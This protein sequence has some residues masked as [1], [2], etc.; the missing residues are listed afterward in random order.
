[1]ASV[2]SKH[3][4]LQNDMLQTVKGLTVYPSEYFNPKDWRTGEVK[5]TINT[6]AIHHED[7]SWL[8]DKQKQSLRRR[9][10]VNKLLGIKLGG[11]WTTWK[12]E[13]CRAVFVKMHKK[14]MSKS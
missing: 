8:N 7:A 3:G 11:A 6:H 9:Q 14:L 4:L 1:M 13:G 5:I 10:R 2:L 12:N